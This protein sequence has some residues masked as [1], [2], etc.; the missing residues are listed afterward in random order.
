MNWARRR[1]PW[2]PTRLSRRRS[3]R[4]SPCEP[5]TGKVTVTLKTPGGEAAAPAPVSQ[6]RPA[7]RREGFRAGRKGEVASPCRVAPAVRSI[8]TWRIALLSAGEPVESV[9]LPFSYHDFSPPRDDIRWVMWDGMAGDSFIGRIIAREFRKAG[10]D[11]AVHRALRVG[12]P[13]EYVAHPYVTRFVDRKTD[14]VP[15]EA[16]GTRMTCSRPML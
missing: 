2:G 8:S 10:L 16:H 12:H 7:G 14:W 11:T 9:R 4:A 13:R 3:R 5:V 6:L 15:G 1:S